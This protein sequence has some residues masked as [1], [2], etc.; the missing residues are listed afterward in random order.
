[1]NGKYFA[2][3]T[4]IVLA[5]GL[6]QPSASAQVLEYR[7]MPLLTIFGNVFVQPSRLNSSQPT[8]YSVPPDTGTPDGRR[9]LGGS[10]IAT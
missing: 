9:T 4:I 10:R 3:L 5:T 2:T 7:N 6:D 8:D 1:M